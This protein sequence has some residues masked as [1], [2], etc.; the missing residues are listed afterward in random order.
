VLAAW[1]GESTWRNPSVLKENRLRENE[2]NG[3]N[4]GADA[5]DEAA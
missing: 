4:T 3:L 2:A 1:D 5:P